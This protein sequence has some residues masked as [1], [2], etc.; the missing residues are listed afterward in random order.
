MVWQ[1]SAL[2]TMGLMVYILS[3]PMYRVS[4]FFFDAVFDNTVEVELLGTVFKMCFLQN[5]EIRSSRK[6]TIRWH[7][8]KTVVATRQVIQEH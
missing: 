5:P 3:R 1:F 6:A 2:S 7:Q 4:H 8:K